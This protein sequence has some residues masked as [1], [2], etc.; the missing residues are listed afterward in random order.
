MFIYVKRVKK[1]SESFAVH[2]NICNNNGIHLQH[3]YVVVIYLK[4]TLGVF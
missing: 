3:F 4:E 2:K 1:L